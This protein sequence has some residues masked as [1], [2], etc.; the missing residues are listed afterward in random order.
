M[1]SKML[2][3]QHCLVASTGIYEMVKTEAGK[4]SY[5]FR[6]QDGRP[7]VMPG[8]AAPRR[9]DDGEGRLCAAI[10]T[11]EPNAFFAGFHNRQVCSL[12]DAELDAWLAADTPEAALACLRGPHDDEWEAVPVDERIFAKGRR[13][14]QDLVPVGPPLRP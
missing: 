11:T 5:W 4:Q 2:G 8:L 12:Q 9:L 13:E 6:R 3:R 1:W 14:L 10:I 7:I